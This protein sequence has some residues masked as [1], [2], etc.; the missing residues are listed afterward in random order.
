MAQVWK[1]VGSRVLALP[2]KQYLTA[3]V[4]LS[5]ALRIAAALYLGNAVQVLPGIEDQQSYDML[6]R[7]VI[8]GH[9]FTVASDWWP[10]TRAGEPTAHW[11]YLY[12]LYLAACYT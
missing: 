10:M 1:V 4:V 11:S 8:T 12:T 3:I 9:G 5:V 6:A 2:V 7:R